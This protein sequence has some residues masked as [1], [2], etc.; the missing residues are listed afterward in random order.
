MGATLIFPSSVPD[1]V[2]YANDARERGETVVAASSLSYD[3]TAKNFDNWIYLPSVYDKVFP[4]CLAKAIR[5]HDI[6]RIFCPVPIAYVALRRHEAEGAISIPIIAEIPIH[7]ALSRHRD[8]MAE[9]ATYHAFIQTIAQGRSPLSRIEIASLIRH[10]TNIFGE[11]GVAKIAA[12][13][14]MFAD[15]PQG[16]VVEIGVLAGRSAYVLASMAR[17]HQ[18]GSVLAIDPWDTAAARQHET[19]DDFRAMLEEWAHVV[20]LE[21]FFESFIVSLLPIGVGNRFNYLAE[22]SRSAYLTWSGQR[23]VETPHFGAVTYAGAIS[24]LHI[25]GNH[26]YV[27]VREDCELWVPRILP[28]GWLILDDYV[29]FHG[30]G[31]HRAGDELLAEHGARIERAF[32]CDKALFVKL[33]S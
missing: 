18:T 28:G 21:D 15:A 6:V 13:M 9:A 1:A 17:R 5:A 10:A 7:R 29:W 24:V 26:D 20:P 2:R 11:T 25:D 30:D 27:H 12:M 31:P 3:G 16:D 22:T 4:S 14:A 33:G 32:V 19:P 23:L 8:L